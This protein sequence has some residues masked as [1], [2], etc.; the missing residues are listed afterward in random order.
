MSDDDLRMKEPADPEPRV[1][2]TAF[3]IVSSFE[4]ADAEDDAYWRSRTPAEHMAHLELLRRI[5]YGD[6]ATGRL[7]KSSGDYLA[8]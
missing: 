6:A 8:P 5:N 4:E 7:Q 2:R 3:S 1:D